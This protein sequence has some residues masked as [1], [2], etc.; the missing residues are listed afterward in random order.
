MAGT[1]RTIRERQR[2][3]ADD[4]DEAAFAAELAGPIAG[5]DEAGRGPWAGPVVAAAVVLPPGHA[6]PGLADSK[7][8]SARAR[9]ALYASITSHAAWGVGQASAAEI[10]AL[11]I[12]AAT[13][14]AFTRALDGLPTPLAGA[15]I[16]GRFAPA[17][18]LPCRCLVKGDARSTAI[19]AAS[20]IAKVTRD[21]LMVALDATH[22]G[23]GFAAHKG[24]GTAAHAASLARLGPSPEHRRT[25]RPVRTALLTLR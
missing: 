18:A 22:P 9:D 20:I 8:L 5:V 17:I 4:R 24:Y 10:D 19:A 21:R 14:L 2:M 13:L 16:D 23:Y 7:T 15:L 1:H 11:N 25:F 12:R 3:C 6:I